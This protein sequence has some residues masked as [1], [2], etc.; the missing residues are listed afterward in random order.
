MYDYIY[1]NYVYIY[2]YIKVIV[3]MWLVVRCYQCYGEHLHDFFNMCHDGL[4]QQK[5]DDFTT[6]NVN[7]IGYLRPTENDS[8]MCQELKTE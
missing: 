8:W 1:I 5:T 6:K 3:G 2:I 7:R 4:N